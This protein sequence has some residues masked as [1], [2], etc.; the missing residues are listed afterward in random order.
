MIAPP[1]EKLFDQGR[2]G[3]GFVAQVAVSKYADHLPLHRQ[4][5]IFA[6]QG[7]DVADTTLLSLVERA[8]AL[9]DPVARAI[10]NSVLQS[11]EES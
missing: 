10:R 2:Q 5:P 7:L 9:L 4:A 8:A 3:K 6:R 11:D 1:P